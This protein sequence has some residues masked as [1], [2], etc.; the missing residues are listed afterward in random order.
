MATWESTGEYLAIGPL[1]SPQLVKHLDL[2]AFGV[3]QL[4]SKQYPVVTDLPI[5]TKCPNLLGFSMPANL[6]NT[7]E[8]PDSTS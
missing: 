1:L 8:R 2:V 3:K 5:F 7:D 6:L 4:H